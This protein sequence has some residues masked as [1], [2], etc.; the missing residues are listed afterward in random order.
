MP[1]DTPILLL[2]ALEAKVVSGEVDLR[3]AVRP[4]HAAP[5]LLVPPRGDAHAGAIHLD[6]AV[7]HGDVTSLIFALGLAVGHVT[8]LG[9]ALG[10]GAVPGHASGRGAIPGLG[11]LRGAVRGLG[12]RRGAVRGLV[13]GHGAIRGLAL[14]RGAIRGL[15]LG[16][17]AVRGPNLGRGVVPGLAVEHRAALKRAVVPG[18]AF[19]R[20]TASGPARGRAGV[21]GDGAELQLGRG[22]PRACPR[23]GVRSDGAPAWSCTA[24]L[25]SQGRLCAGRCPR[26]C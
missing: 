20:G 11:V 19:G 7:G 18:L 23:G 6:R 21:P 15:D 1:C 16:R 12:L 25:L 26:R 17:G 24:L 2:D 14:G 22:R 5:G 8:V 4:Q 13:R 9:L 3:Q 10:R